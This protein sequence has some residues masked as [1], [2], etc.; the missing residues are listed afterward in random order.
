VELRHLSIDGINYY[1][2]FHHSNFNNTFKKY[3]KYIGTKLPTEPELYSLE[4]EM[5]NNL[6]KYQIK[7]SDKNTIELLQQTQDKEGF[8]SKES[9]VKMSKEL[10]IPLIELTGIATFY[11]EF[12]LVKQGKYKIKICNGTAC[13]VKH[14]SIV[15]NTIQKVLGIKPGELSKDEKFSFEIVNCIGACAR[16]P[17]MMINDDIY[18][19]LTEEKVK[20]IIGS[21][22]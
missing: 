18:G 19:E 6:D 17:A 21:L 12:K 20:K 1:Y 10:D 9:F 15:I 3:K 11:S 14:S 4:G 5:F 13:N 8:I 16:A 7:K 2:L 22:K